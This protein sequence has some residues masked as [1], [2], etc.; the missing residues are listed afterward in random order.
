MS[1]DNIKPGDTVAVIAAA[2]WSRGAPSKATV[3]RTTTTQV[4]VNEGMLFSR[5]SGFGVGS[6]GYWR[7]EPWGEQHDKAVAVAVDDA[8]RSRILAA[9]EDR[10]KTR[11]LTLDQLRRIA[12]ILGEDG[13]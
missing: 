11:K 1:L 9:M 2:V 13:T 4:V 12:A 10:G 7:I 8:E 3:S 5:R 6:G